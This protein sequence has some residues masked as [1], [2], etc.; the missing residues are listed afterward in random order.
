MILHPGHTLVDPGCVADLNHNGRIEPDETEHFQVRDIPA[1]VAAMRPDVRLTP[2]TLDYRQVQEWALGTGDHRFVALHVNASNPPGSYGAI[3]YATCS[4]HGRNLAEDMRRSLSLLLPE[5]TWK[6]I[7]L[8]AVGWERAW[9]CIRVISEDRRPMCAVLVELG[10]LASPLTASWWTEE[11]RQR[12][13]EAVAG[14][15]A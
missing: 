1:R 7:A 12:V 4:D 2:E 11:G 14:G 15:I 13:A 8:P 3:Y 9:S 10:F 5:V 6:L